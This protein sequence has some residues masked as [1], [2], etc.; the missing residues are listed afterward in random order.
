MQEAGWSGELAGDR[1]ARLARPDRLAVRRELCRL[2]A[3]LPRRSRRRGARPWVRVV[4]KTRASRSNPVRS[5]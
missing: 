1:R 5:V 4:R 2:A 3:A